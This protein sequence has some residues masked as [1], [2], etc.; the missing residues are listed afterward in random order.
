MSFRSSGDDEGFTILD[1]ETNKSIK[2]MTILKSGP[3]VQPSTWRAD[4]KLPDVCDL[5]QSAVCAAAIATLKEV[6]KVILKR[7]ECV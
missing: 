5:C 7:G 3:R 1:L 6:W 4:R 2:L